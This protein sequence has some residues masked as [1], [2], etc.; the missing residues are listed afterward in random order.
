MDMTEDMLSKMVLEITGSYK[1]SYQSDPDGKGEE[2]EID[3]TP[4]WPRLSMVKELNKLL[5][6]EIPIEL[7]SEE[8]RSYLEALV[9]P[10]LKEASLL[11]A[12]IGQET[13]SSVL[14][15]FDLSKATG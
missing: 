6:V 3:F 14:T 11:S 12:L 2:I 7:E 1:I 5:D 15:S 9:S 4:P 10:F 8:S 13:W